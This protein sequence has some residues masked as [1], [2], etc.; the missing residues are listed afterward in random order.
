[1]KCIR[2]I[3]LMIILTILILPSVIGG[4]ITFNPVSIGPEANN[5]YCGTEMTPEYETIEISKSVFGFLIEEGTYDITFDPEIDW[6]KEY[7]DIVDNQNPYLLA[8]YS[9]YMKKNTFDYIGALV[10]KPNNKVL[11]VIFEYGGGHK[12]KKD[13]S[14]FDCSFFGVK[15]GDFG[16]S[17]EIEQ[18]CP[19]ENIDTIDLVEFSFMRTTCNMVYSDEKKEHMGHKNKCYNAGDKIDTGGDDDLVCPDFPCDSF[20]HSCVKAKD[21]CEMNRMGE[22]VYSVSEEM[23][24]LEP[25][26]YLSCYCRPEEEWIDI[27][28][29]NKFYDIMLEENWPKKAFGNVDDPDFYYYRCIECPQGQNENLLGYCI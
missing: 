2:N 25:E 18:F 9:T 19:N 3:I 1:M 5:N 16:G 11:D 13:Y 21:C 6:N 7:E 22:L 4:T 28:G 8:K 17:I 12:C 10:L 29:N 20:Y 26:K 14:S 23:Y 27:M 15:E 24:D